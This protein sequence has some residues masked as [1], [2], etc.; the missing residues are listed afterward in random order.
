MKKKFRSFNETKEYAHSLGIKSQREWQKAVSERIIAKNIHKNPAR[1]FGKEWRGW[2]DFLGTYRIANQEKKFRSFV[3]ARKFIRKLKLKSDTEWQKYC[4]SG[5]LPED[6]PK[7]PREVYE[8]EWEGMGDWIGTGRM[9]NQNRK[10]RSFNKTKE[11]VHSLG[12]KS[13]R[14]WQ[15]YCKSG[16]KPLDIPSGPDRTYKKEW[17]GWG[18]FLGTEVT[19]PQIISKNYLSLK[20]AK[21]KAR[22]IKLELFGSRPI[23]REE[24]VQA[25]KDGK[26]PA[27]IPR[28]PTQI[29]GKKRK[30]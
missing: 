26:I 4:K 22:K 11:Y 23:T 14:E 19:A 18:D 28:Y 2:G 27:N 15:K 24:W 9:A 30:K 3:S 1:G 17:S 21:K 29:Y 20:D 5:K 8:D 25:Y 16:K 13:Q 7:T 12:I 6:I 10:F